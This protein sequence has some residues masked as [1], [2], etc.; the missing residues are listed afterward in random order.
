MKRVRRAVL[1]LGVVMFGLRG[2]SNV[3]VLIFGSLPLASG[4]N[5]TEGAEGPKFW[6]FLFTPFLIYFRPNLGRSRLKS[7]LEQLM[8]L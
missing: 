5:Y 4:R 2:V 8:E 7:A 6:T 3:A 1:C